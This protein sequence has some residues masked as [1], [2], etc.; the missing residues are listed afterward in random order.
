MS[1]HGTQSRYN[2]GRCRCDA[3]REAHTAYL[4]ERNGHRATSDC[5]VPGQSSSL[6]AAL[7]ANLGAA[8]AEVF[9]LARLANKSAQRFAQYRDELDQAKKDRAE[10]RQNIRDHMAECPTAAE[11]FGASA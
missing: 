10:V 11:R 5:T 1:D 7:A 3:C 4:R 9:R 6:C 2:N 8:E